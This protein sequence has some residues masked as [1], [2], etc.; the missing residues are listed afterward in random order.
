MQSAAP[1]DMPG[2]T[3]PTTLG[4]DAS[5]ARQKI[6]DF[7]AQRHA[8]KERRI[9]R[10]LRR[11]V[12]L[13]AFGIITDIADGVSAVEYDVTTYLVLDIMVVLGNLYVA[14]GMV[15]AS[16]GLHGI[17]MD[18]FLTASRLRL[19]PFGVCFVISVRVCAREARVPAHAGPVCPLCPPSR[20]LPLRA[21]VRSCKASSGL[22]TACPDCCGW[23]SA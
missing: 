3:D 15:L 8:A 14:V 19:L 6:A 16:T 22:G 17:D 11:G 9:W 21:R 7:K 10:V 5:N 13:V 23:V 20:R 12:L 18:A 2:R 4:W 1:S